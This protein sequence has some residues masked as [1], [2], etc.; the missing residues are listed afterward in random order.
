M[1]GPQPHGFTDE[2]SKIKVYE[3]ISIMFFYAYEYFRKFSEL[4]S[5]N[6]AY[7]ISSFIQQQK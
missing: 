4:S 6:S 7:L 5:Y 2:Y 1:I 3:E